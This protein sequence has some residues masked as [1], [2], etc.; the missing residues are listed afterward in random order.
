MVNLAD[1]F[2]GERRV[3]AVDRYAQR[4]V[5]IRTIDALGASEIVPRPRRAPAPPAP[6]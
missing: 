5:S 2:S 1:E 6:R 4:R 3:L